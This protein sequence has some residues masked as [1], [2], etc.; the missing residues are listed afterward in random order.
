MW[1]RIPNRH[2]NSSER[3]LD[4]RTCF[5]ATSPNWFNVFCKILLQSMFLARIINKTKPKSQLLILYRE[6]KLEPFFTSQ[7]TLCR[8]GAIGLDLIRNSPLFWM[9]KKY[10]VYMRH[11]GCNISKS[12]R[13]ISAK[14]MF[15]IPLCNPIFVINLHQ[16]LFIRQRDWNVCQRMEFRESE[17]HY[18]FSSNRTEFSKL[19]NIE[20]VSKQKVEGVPIGLFSLYVLFS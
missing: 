20:L 4:F 19:C 14:M 1:N 18:R 7:V 13:V 12:K 15:Q 16:L 17:H 10:V 6:H 3:F 9:N 8:S 11:V 5:E 2:T